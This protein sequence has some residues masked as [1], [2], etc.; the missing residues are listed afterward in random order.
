MRTIFTVAAFLAALTFAAAAQAGNLT[1]SG[2]NGQWQSSG[3]TEPT[4]PASLLAADRETHAGD[5][6]KMMEGYNAYATAMHAYMTC[7]SKEAESDG[8]AAAATIS[9]G[10]NATIQGAQGK[11]D[12]LHATLS[13]K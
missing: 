7:V 3:C 4:P 2:G 10:A 8:S 11:V 5:M 13:K 9:Q 6:N 12:A 1:L